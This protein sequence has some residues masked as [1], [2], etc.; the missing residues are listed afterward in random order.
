MASQKGIGI[1]TVKGNWQLDN[2]IQSKIIAMPFSMASEIE[3]DLISS[4]T[5]EALRSLKA[6]DVKLGR[7]PGPRRALSPVPL[8]N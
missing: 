8:V 1:F 4:R 2:T 5:T 3:R 7:P 6:R